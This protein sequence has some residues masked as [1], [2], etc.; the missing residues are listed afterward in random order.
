MHVLHKSRLTSRLV[1][2]E[3]TVI[4]FLPTPRP[5]VGQELSCK[6][7]MAR[8]LAR[9]R[10]VPPLYVLE[11]VVFHRI[12]EST[13]SPLRRLAPFAYQLPNVGMLTAAVPSPTLFGVSVMQDII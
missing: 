2:A 3:A 12:L 8:I 6:P 4:F 7:A 13:L 10:S 9:S 11:M 5:G 1:L